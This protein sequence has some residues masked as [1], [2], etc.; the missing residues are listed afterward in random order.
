MRGWSNDSDRMPV[1]A[2]PMISTFVKF[3]DIVN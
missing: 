2:S 3:E 1:T